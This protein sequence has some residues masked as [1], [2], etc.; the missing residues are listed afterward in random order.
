MP[1]EA[2]WLKALSE[3]R[4][5]IAAPEGMWLMRE[6]GSV[7]ACLWC[8]GR[9]RQSARNARK[10]HDRQCGLCNGLTTFA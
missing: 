2:A 5:F 1:R 10:E 8:S 7:A 9:R 4:C 6:G 3:V